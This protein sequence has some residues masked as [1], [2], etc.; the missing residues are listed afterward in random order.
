MVTKPTVQPP[1]KDWKERVYNDDEMIGYIIR[2]L[3]DH[4]GRS[5]TFA[6]VRTVLRLAKDYRS[7]GDNKCAYANGGV[8]PTE[9]QLR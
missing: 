3:E 7:R 4:H 1:P 9:V 8:S 6:D 2:R 5:L